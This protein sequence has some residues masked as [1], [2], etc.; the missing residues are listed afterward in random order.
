MNATQSPVSAAAPASGMLVLSPRAAPP[1]GEARL[2]LCALV[3]AHGAF[4]CLTRAFDLQAEFGPDANASFSPFSNGDVM[5]FQRDV[6]RDAIVSAVLMFEAGPASGLVECSLLGRSITVDLYR[7]SPGYVALR[8]DPLET[9]DLRQIWAPL[10][11]H[12]IGEKNG[13]SRG[14]QCV[15]SGV[16]TD[17]PRV[18]VQ[19]EAVRRFHLPEADIERGDNGD[20]LINRGICVFSNPQ[21]AAVE[22]VCHDWAGLVVLRRGPLLNAV[23][24]FSLERCKGLIVGESCD[25]AI[26]KNTGLGL[27]EQPL[28]GAF[29]DVFNP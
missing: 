9:C 28:F 22:V 4:R 5:S 10:E 12:V 11:I 7:P 13:R 24:L 19:N 18:R 15:I 2:R 17:Y 16:Y 29:V 1:G 8:L 3:D 25:I 23:D 6:C 14:T 20:V 26:G 27:G 21:R